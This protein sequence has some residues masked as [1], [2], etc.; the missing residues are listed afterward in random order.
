[1]V[2]ISIPQEPPPLIGPIYHQL[3][4]P[5]ISSPNSIHTLS[6]PSVSYATTT[7]LPRL[8]KNQSRS[9]STTP[10]SSK[11]TV[12][13]TVSGAYPSIPTHHK[14]MHC[15]PNKHNGTLSN[16][17]T[18]LPSAQVSALSSRPPNIIFSSHGPILHPKSFDA[19]YNPLFPPPKAISTNNDNVAANHPAKRHHQLTSPHELTPFTQQFSIPNNQPATPSVTSLADSQFSQIVGPTTSSYSM[20]TTATLSSS[21]L[22]ATAAHKKSNESSAPSTPT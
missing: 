9:T 2:T 12:F 8:T 16:G 7:A 21:D 3:P 20:T 19:T 13:Q 10:Q 18:L 11:V 22:Y 14:P 15:S 1:M 4:E 17:S 5:P 6:S